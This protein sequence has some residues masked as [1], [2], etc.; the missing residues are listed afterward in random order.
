M[1]YSAGVIDNTHTPML[2]N[3]KSSESPLKPRSSAG[4]MILYSLLFH[5]H[6]SFEKKL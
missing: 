6:V 2:L 4:V 3:Q 5:L 1:G